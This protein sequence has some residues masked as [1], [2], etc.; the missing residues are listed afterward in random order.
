MRVYTGFFEGAV[1]SSKFCFKT[2]VIAYSSVLENFTYYLFK[3]PLIIPPIK[4]Y[5]IVFTR[6]HAEKK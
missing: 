1:E 3:H 2:K 6:R 4:R 5:F